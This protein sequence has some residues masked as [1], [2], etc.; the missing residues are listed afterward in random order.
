MKVCI[1]DIL[2]G[3]LRSIQHKLSLLGIESLPCSNPE[4]LMRADIV[5]L[6][7]VGN[8]KMAMKNLEASGLADILKQKILV[9]KTPLLGIC[10]GMQLLTNYSEEG[11]V[12]G[13]GW[14]DAT[15]KK[16][17]FSSDDYCI[18]HIGWTEIN[19]KQET[20]LNAGIEDSSSYY[21]THSYYVEANNRNEVIGAAT[22]DF[23]FDAVIRK[24]NI[25]GVQFHPEKSH[26]HGMQVLKNFIDYYKK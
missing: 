23:E 8:F 3:N 13:L 6:P 5:I 21:F 12:K 22:Y 16:F 25:W 2:I 11:D 7:G 9:E 20:I 4:E 18:P 24:E 15:T 26:R 19:W 14:I 1:L 17:K 10:L